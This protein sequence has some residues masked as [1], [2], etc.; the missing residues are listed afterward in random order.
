[1]T[2]KLTPSRRELV[3]SMVGDIVQAFDDGAVEGPEIRPARSI[4]SAYHKLAI[5]YILNVYPG[6]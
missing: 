2:V 1:M 6:F 3:S 5:C 4:S